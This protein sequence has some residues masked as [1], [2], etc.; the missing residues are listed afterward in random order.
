MI[1]PPVLP[2]L[3]TIA[4]PPVLAWLLHRYWPRFRAARLLWLVIGVWLMGLAPACGLMAE[5]VLVVAL[6]ANG[7]QTAVSL[8]YA[9]GQPYHQSQGW[10]GEGNWEGRDY[11]AGCGVK[12]YAPL[13]GTA[14]AV[15]FDGFI[16]KYGRNN[17]FIIFND[18]RGREV[19]LLHGEYEIEPGTAVVAGVTE[20]GREASVGNSSGC[21]TH[22][23]LRV[24][25]TA[26]DPAKYL[27]D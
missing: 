4:L 9:P 11:S 10:H 22:F 23:T 25:G 18:G 8:P 15:G 12:L 3:F 2:P 7:A 5:A 21:H 13:T 14:T 17:S 24:N 19:V 16:G 26:V 1:L 20:I 6:E 27:E